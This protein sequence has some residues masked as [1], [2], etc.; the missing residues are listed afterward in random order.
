M[1]VR[2]FYQITGGN[3]EEALRLLLD[4]GRIL[5]YIRLFPSDPSFAALGAA[6][7]EGDAEAAFGAAHAL[8]GVCLTLSFEETGREASAVTEA[9]RA[10]NLDQA[11]KLFPSLAEKYE[12]VLQ[13]L[14]ETEA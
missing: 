11:R 1:N 4:D 12:A 13:A 3:Y 14:R 6:L 7:E 2:Q 10:G 8:K 5:R 9:L